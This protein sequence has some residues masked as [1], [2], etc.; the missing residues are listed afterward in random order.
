MG[1]NKECAM[2]KNVNLPVPGDEMR[3][4]SPEDGE[5]GGRSEKSVNILFFS[6]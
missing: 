1:N 4:S 6:L 5:N 3:R 2:N